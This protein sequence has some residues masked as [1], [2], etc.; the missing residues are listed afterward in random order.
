[1]RVLIRDLKRGL[2]DLKRAGKFDKR[3]VAGIATYGK[4]LVTSCHTSGYFDKADNGESLCLKAQTSYFSNLSESIL[5]RN[6]EHSPLRNKLKS[7]FTTVHQSLSLVFLFVTP[8]L[9]IALKGKG[10][11]G[12]LGECKKFSLSDDGLDGYFVNYLTC[13]TNGDYGY[14]F[15]TYLFF[16]LSALLAGLLLQEKITF[17]SFVYRFSGYLSRN[18]RYACRPAWRVDLV[19]VQGMN[20]VRL[21]LRWLYRTLE[22]F[23]SAPVYYLLWTIVLGGLGFVFTE[24]FASGISLIM[25]ALNVG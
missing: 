25:D 8:L 19:L 16:I 3:D 1:M 6:D 10:A 13:V 24:L 2:V 23:V 18:A 9:L 7:F 14:I 22:F 11:N 15:D 4:S 21:G 12:E 17:Q 5:L 20:S